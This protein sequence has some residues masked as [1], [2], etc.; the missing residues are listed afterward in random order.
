[1]SDFLLE[2]RAVGKTYVLGGKPLP[3]LRSATA[4]FAAGAYATVRGASGS[5]KSTFLQILG[6]LQRPD[7]GEVF[8][9]GE[10]VRAYSR[11][12]LAAWRG[13]H[14]GFVFQSYQL[15]PEFTALENVEMPAL[16]RGRGDPRRGRA[17]LERVGLGSRADHRPAELSGGEQQRVAIARALRNDPALLLADEPTGNLDRET[18]AQIVAL[19]ETLHREEGKTLVLVTHDEQ[20]AARGAQRLVVVEGHLDEIP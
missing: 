11:A 2:A 4:R 7:A 10:A 12:K 16:I 6:G 1:M 8:W 15:L 13:E 17:L 9:R 5:G 19:L 18:G 20:I 3:V 14:V